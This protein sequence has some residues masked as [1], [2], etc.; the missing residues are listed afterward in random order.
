MTK[1]PT[2]LDD[3]AIAIS[4]LTTMVDNR[5][6]TIES[7][8]AYMNGEIRTIREQLTRIDN[9]ITGVESDIT[10]TVR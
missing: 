4:D 8:S 7:D 10:E 9:R 3:I 1:K 2:D 5:F 6:S